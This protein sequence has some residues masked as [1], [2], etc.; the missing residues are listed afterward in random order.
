MITG[1]INDQLTLSLLLVCFPC[2]AVGFNLCS[3][4]SSNSDSEGRICYYYS[5][6]RKLTVIPGSMKKQITESHEYRSPQF[7][8]TL[9]KIMVSGAWGDRSVAK[10][11]AAQAW[12]PEFDSQHTHKIAST[13]VWACNPSTGKNGNR[14]IVELDRQP[15]QLHQW[16]LGSQRDPISKTNCCDC[17]WLRTIISFELWSPCLCMWKCGTT[18]LYPNY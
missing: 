15:V 14:R 13:V 10:R 1:K 5:G 8:A 3:W 18:H 12:G 7:S 6:Q 9:G 2:L 11:L 16:A 17:K 4:L